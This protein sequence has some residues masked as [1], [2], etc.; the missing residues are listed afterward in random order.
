M[1]MS[2]HPRYSVLG[3]VVECLGTL[4]HGPGIMSGT[5]PFGAASR[6]WARAC[7]SRPSKKQIPPTVLCSGCAAA[8]PP[9]DAMPT[10]CLSCPF[11]PQRT[12]PLPEMELFSCLSSPQA[13]AEDIPGPITE[14]VGPMCCCIL[15]SRGWGQRIGV[16]AELKTLL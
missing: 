5:T 7:F 1:H 14:L 4:G 3:H 16:L 11:S 9:P 15:R 13:G 2:A 6:I 12:Q 10:L 8:L